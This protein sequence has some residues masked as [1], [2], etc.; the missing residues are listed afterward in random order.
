MKRREFLVLADD[1]PVASQQ[2]STGSFHLHPCHLGERT[3]PLASATNLPRHPEPRVP[4]T[5]DSVAVMACINP[6][7]T[8]RHY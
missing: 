5:F 8:D 3:A 6:R 2:G 1:A 4:A 7:P